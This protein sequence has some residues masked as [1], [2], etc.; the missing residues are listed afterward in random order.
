MEGEKLNKSLAIFQGKKIRRVWHEGEWWF[1]IVDVIEALT[2]SVN[3]RQYIKNMRNRDEELA[4]GWVQIEHTL[5]VETAGG[6]QGMS[7]SN[8]EGIF[9]IVQSVSS[10]RAEPFKRWL[11]KLGYERIQEIDDPELAQER[12]KRIYEE[13]GYSKGWIDKR[14]RGIVVRQGLTDEWE[15]RGVE[16]GV[17]FAI[18]T[19][20]ISRATFGFNTSEYKKFKGL[21]R[22][23]LRDHMTDLE[24]IF[25]ML[26]EASTTE[27]EKV[28]N[29]ENFGEH[30]D[31]ARKGGK[32]ARG[33]REELEVETGKGIISDENYLEI[34]EKTK[35]GIA[36]EVV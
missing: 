8:T 23:N 26:G 5:L 28:Q 14:L 25:S 3:P 21:E 24:L 2:N 29:P 1:V 16:K 31:A 30:R 18:L 35:R 36:E 7:C 33:A 20:E 13:K 10:R 9:R 32:I 15:K 4:K 22:E 11:A 19:D 17:E 6:K 34:T 12:M 27:I